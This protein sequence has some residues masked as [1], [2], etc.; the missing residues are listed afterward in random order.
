VRDSEYQVLQNAHNARSG[1]R[2]SAGAGRCAR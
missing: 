2:R 1:R